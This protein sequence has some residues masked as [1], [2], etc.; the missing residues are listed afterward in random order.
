MR[1][2]PLHR[3]QPSRARGAADRV[4]VP[5]HHM[6]RSLPALLGAGLLLLACGGDR[7]AGPVEPR[8]P[9]PVPAKHFDAPAEPVH[10]TPH[11][12]KATDIS[13]FI[14]VNP[15]VFRRAEADRGDADVVRF[16][17]AGLEGEHYGPTDVI[18]R[19]LARRHTRR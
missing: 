2:R 6:E 16:D 12:L 8:E 13:G 4:R 14:P 10:F 1:T 15:R 18:A 19:V 5:L 3:A 7:L 17:R 11:D 9:L